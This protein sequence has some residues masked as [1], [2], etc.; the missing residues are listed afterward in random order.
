MGLGI[1]AVITAGLGVDPWTVLTLG[2]SHTFNLTPGRASQIQAVIIMAGVYLFFRR[3]PGLGTLLNMFLVG[4]FIDT[5]SYFWPTPTTLIGQLILLAAGIII[6][7]AGVGTYVSGSLGEG[8][9]EQLMLALT[10]NGRRHVGRVRIFMDFSATVIGC[11]LGGTVGLGTLISVVG[12]GLVVEKTLQLL[13][14]L[15]E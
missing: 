6:L 3:R 14:S 13:P 9:I 1:T 11:L 5:F 7:G 12:I 10:E 15:A 2:T 8:P 4:F